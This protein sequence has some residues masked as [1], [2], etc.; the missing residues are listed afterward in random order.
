MKR[1]LSILFRL[2]ND[3]N[4]IQYITLYTHVYILIS[5]NLKESPKTMLMFTETFI[6]ANT[7]KWTKKSIFSKKDEIT[8]FAYHLIFLQE[9]IYFTHSI[10]WGIFTSFA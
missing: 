5:L 6:A 10:H 8:Y 4:L 2:N 3:Y 7:I 9:K 1:M